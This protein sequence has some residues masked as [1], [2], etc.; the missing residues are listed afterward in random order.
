MSQNVEIVRR[1][2]D[3]LRDSYESGEATDG[4]LDLCTPDVRVD[5]TRRVFNRTSTRAMRVYG[6]RYERSVTP[7]RTSTKVPSGLSTPETAS[8]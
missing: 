6:A 2:L 8:L 5:A 3:L 1:A 7:G 4:L